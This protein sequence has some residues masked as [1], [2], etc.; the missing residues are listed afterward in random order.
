[1]VAAAATGKTT[2]KGAARLRLKESD[3]LATTAA[4]LTAVGGEV[5]VTADGLIITGGTPLSGG[6]VDAAGD[7][8]IAMS[9]AALAL[10]TNG[11]LNILGA[12]AISK[13]YPTFFKEVFPT[14]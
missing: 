3:R 11:P 1:M 9:G 7:H 6:T 10:L 8:R 5:T 4:M 12:E 2:I 13:S 14:L